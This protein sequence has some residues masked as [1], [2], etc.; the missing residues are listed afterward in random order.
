MLRLPLVALGALLPLLASCGSGGSDSPGAGSGGSLQDARIV[1]DSRVA[2][3]EVVVGVISA[4]ALEGPSGT[5]SG[6]LLQT[7]VRLELATPA[8]QVQ[9]VELRGVPADLQVAAR[10]A[11]APGSLYLRA[12]NGTRVPIADGEVRIPFGTPLNLRNARHVWVRHRGNAATRRDTN[13]ATRFAASWSAGTD[14]TIALVDASVEVASLNG[15]EVK[16]FVDAQRRIAGNLG[17]GMSPSLWRDG[18]QI[19]STQFVRGL[20]A[21]HRL[22]LRGWL[23]DSGRIELRSCD[24]KG[25]RR[26]NESKIVGRVTA[27]ETTGKLLSVRVFQIRYGATGWPRDPLPVTRVNYS[28]AKLRDSSNRRQP[29]NPSAFRVGTWVEVEWRG[30]QAPS[31]VRAHEVELEHGRDDAQS[32]EIEGAI[33]SINTAAGRI[34]VVPREDNP[35]IVSGKRVSRAVVVVGANTRIVRRSDTGP[36]E[37]KLGDVKTSDRIWIFGRVLTNGEIDAR[38]VRVR[39]DSR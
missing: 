28:T 23:D 32:P 15:S 36:I 4:I 8:S 11:F 38:Y 24:D 20:S 10:L 9:S 29:V 1:L 31:N 7:P 25:Q 22:V 3:G 5:L 18:R 17:Y 39:D 6:N 26:T 21:G 14:A 33:E 19:N 13:G 2:S 12:A 30:E 34:V 16:V 27:H 37:I 35:L